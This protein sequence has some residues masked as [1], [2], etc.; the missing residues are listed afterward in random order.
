MVQKL[1]WGIRAI[2]L[3]PFF[4]RLGL[5]TYIGKPI[6]VNGARKISIGK[7]VRIFPGLRIEVHGN[8]GE[9]II[10][11]NVAIAQ[12]VHITAMGKLVINEGTTILGNVFITDI[13][14]SYKEIGKPVFDQAMIYCKTEIGKNCMIG[15]GA[16]IQ[17]GTILGEQCIVGANAVV[18]G[19]YPSFSVIVGVPAK[20]IKKY[21]FNTDIWRE[22]AP[23]PPPPPQNSII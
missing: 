22:D 18:K 15:Y 17:A 16:A 4:R 13:E 3:M 1:L 5:P 8:E 23:P 9:I 21:D 7:R 19:K 2:F 6:V 20:V 10:K 11:N 12:N 14:H